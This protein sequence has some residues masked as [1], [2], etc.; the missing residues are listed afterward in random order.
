M[1]QVNRLLDLIDERNKAGV[2]GLDVVVSFVHRRVYPIKER[3]NLGFE[4]SGADDPTRESDAAW[5][6]GALMD[7]LKPL[8]ASD[9][10]LNNDG[11][12]R[13]YSLDKPADEVLVRILE[14]SC[15]VLLDCFPE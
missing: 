11:C 10:I 8:F 14:S 2:T 1:D 5:T 15:L 7:R 4:F 12:P 6:S 9:V 13:P 3:V